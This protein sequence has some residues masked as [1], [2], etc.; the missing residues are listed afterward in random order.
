VNIQ[1]LD[2]SVHGQTI[3]KNFSLT[4]PKGATVG[5]VGPNGAGKSTL[6][7]AIAGHPHYLITSGTITLDGKALHDL[8]AH[9]RAKAGVF[10]AFQ[11]PPEIPGVSVRTFFHEMYRAIKGESPWITVER[12]MTNA[13]V[14]VGLPESCAERALNHG[15]SGGEKKLLEAAQ[16]LFLKPRIAI[17][18]ELDS[19]L[20]STG[21][22]WVPTLL[23]QCR[24][25]NPE[26]SALVISHNP[27]VIDA[28]KPTLVHQY[29][30]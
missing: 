14:T 27:L 18:D 12:A 13:L 9:E 10:L 16:L 2:V 7:Y 3:V 23:E 17:L 21:L 29:A 11:T 25:E 5:L 15:F 6:A 1:G 28:L 24:K 19:G 22:A 4:I 20:D 8:P 30:Q 26:F